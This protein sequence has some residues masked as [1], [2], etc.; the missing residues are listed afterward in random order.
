MATA[1]PCPMRYRP[2]R[3]V[4]RRRLISGLRPPDLTVIHPEFDADAV[5]SPNNSGTLLLFYRA[6]YRHPIGQRLVSAGLR[7]LV[8]VHGAQHAFD[9]RRHSKG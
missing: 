3:I 8:M 5:P 2:S 7:D 9:D 1:T 4:Q 6:P